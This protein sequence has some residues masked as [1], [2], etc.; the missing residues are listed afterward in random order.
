MR[1]QMWVDEERMVGFEAQVVLLLAWGLVAR[2]TGSGMR[3]VSL[4]IVDCTWARRWG[5]TYGRHVAITYCSV[6]VVQ[7]FISFPVQLRRWILVHTLR[8]NGEYILWGRLPHIPKLIEPFQVL[9]CRC[10]KGETQA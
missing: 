10:V 6:F 5:I 4:W 3:G 7:R 9:V 1:H 2:C 8:N